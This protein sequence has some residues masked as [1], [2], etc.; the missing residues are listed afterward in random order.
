MASGAKVGAM[1]NADALATAQVTG[2]TAGRAD[3]LR[4]GPWP[5]PGAAARRF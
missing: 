1:L 2:A 5:G 4:P 3:D